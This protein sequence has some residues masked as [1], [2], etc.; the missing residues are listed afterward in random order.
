MLCALEAGDA[1]LRDHRQPGWPVCA[2][3]L[4]V[5]A[6]PIPGYAPCMTG[7]GQAQSLPRSGIVG[8]NEHLDGA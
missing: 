4:M 5:F 8:V 2:I 7:P 3:E 6:R 1:Y